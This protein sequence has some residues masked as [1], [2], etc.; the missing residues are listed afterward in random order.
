M[1]DVIEHIDPPRRTL[2]RVHELLRPR[3]LLL[4]VTPDAA[5]LSAR[6][7]GRRWP[8]LLPEHVVCFSRD[9]LRRLLA[10]TGFDV[11]DVGFAW[12]KVNLEMVVR[13]AE[14]HREVA[15]GGVLRLLGRVLPN[16]LRKA[17]IRFNL[18][19][20]YVIARRSEGS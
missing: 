11:F 3:G 17:L 12:K 15:G 1:F 6:V 14:L 7:L 20:F 18:G 5:S 4:L 13:H 9:G 8:H 19:E 16:W 2:E 10:A